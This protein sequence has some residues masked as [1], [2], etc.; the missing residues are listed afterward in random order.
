MAHYVNNADF[1][2]AIA[3]Y[4]KEVNERNYKYNVLDDPNL[5]I[6][7]SGKAKL[8]YPKNEGDYIIP[9]DRLVK[10]SAIDLLIST[11]IYKTQLTLQIIL[12]FSYIYKS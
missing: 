8:N 9:T 3:K 2:A 5:I 10:I 6:S 7:E 11:C 1:L 12:W 4:K